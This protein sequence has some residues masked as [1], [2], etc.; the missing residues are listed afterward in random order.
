MMTKAALEEKIEETRTIMIYTASIMGIL[1]A[2]T[3][4]LSQSL[5]TYIALYQLLN[6]S[7]S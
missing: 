4:Q 1:S 3:I 7:E 2:E 6:K 5:D